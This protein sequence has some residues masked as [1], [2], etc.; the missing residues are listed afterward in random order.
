[1]NIIETKDIAREYIMGTNVVKAL[2]SVSVN[3]E[4]GEYVAFMGP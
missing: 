3:V 2:K 4:K 1:M